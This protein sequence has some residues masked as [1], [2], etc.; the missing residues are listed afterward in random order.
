MIARSQICIHFSTRTR[1]ENHWHAFTITSVFGRLEIL[2]APQV[3][4]LA[5]AEFSHDHADH[6]VVRAGRQMAVRGIAAEI[7]ELIDQ[8]LDVGP[9]TVWVAERTHRVK[10]TS[11]AAHPSPRPKGPR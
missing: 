1:S 4:G 10:P 6:G 2:Q 9:R 3:D 5:G 11:P 7:D 8:V